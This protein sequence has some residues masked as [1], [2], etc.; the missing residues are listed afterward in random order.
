MEESGRV[1]CNSLDTGLGCE[2]EMMSPDNYK[3]LHQEEPSAAELAQCEAEV[4]MLLSIIAEVN[5]K[6][7]SLKAPSDSGDSSTPRPSSPLFPDLLSH[8]LSRCG[9]EKKSD[10]SSKHRAPPG[11]VVWCNLQDAI[12]AVED[13]IQ[14]R[15]SWAVPLALSDQ[16]KHREHLRAAQDSWTKTSQILEDMEREFGISC[17]SLP[18]LQQE[19]L[20]QG[21]RLRSSSQSQ[22][23]EAERCVMEEERNKPAGHHWA[24]RSGSVSP[25]YRHAAVPLPPDW[26]SQSVPNSPLIFR[27]SARAA[28]LSSVG[29]DG[30]SMGSLHSG[31]PCPINPDGEMERLTRYV[32]K[33]KCRNERLTAA[34][35]RKRAESD[36][37]LMTVKRLESDCSALQAAL[38]HCGQSE[39]VYDEL[40]ALYDAKKQHGSLHRAEVCEEPQPNDLLV[41]ISQTDTEEISTSFST[42]GGAEETLC[43]GGQRN[44][45]SAEREVFLLRQLDRLKRERAALCIPKL[46]LAAVEGQ[47]S[48]DC[49]SRASSLTQE[50]TRPAEGRREKLVCELVSAREEISDLRA[51]VHLKEKELRCLEWTLMARKVTGTSGVLEPENAEEE[52][53]AGRTEQ[54]RLYECR[55]ILTLQAVLHREQVMK[56]RMALVRDSDSAPNRC[57][58]E[59]QIARLTHAHSKALSAYRHLRRKYREHVWRLEQKVMAMAESQHNQSESSQSEESEWRREETVL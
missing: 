30:S 15:R 12:S 43:T 26:T 57:N 11:G 38:R 46:N 3:N 19:S 25:S 13:S 47:M 40:L 54:Q 35:D 29:G 36:Q 56:R 34:M 39:E 53:E 5:K 21:T 51:L 55:P 8:R 49:G 50:L 28:P 31:S 27:K 41:H 23:R 17:P 48:S 33:L 37:L 32:E 7:G 42:A 14:C 59:D 6:M 1:R 22:Q 58:G 4:R 44:P 24:W 10:S 45:E 52:Q 2:K 9:P 16:D 18:T 20:D